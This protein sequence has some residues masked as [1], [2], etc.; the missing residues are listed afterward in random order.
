MK[1]DVEGFYAAIRKN[2]DPED[3][4]GEV[5]S[6]TVHY[7]KVFQKGELINWNWVACLFAPIWMLYRRLYAAYILL[8][9]IS[10][11]LSYLPTGVLL[12]GLVINV[13]IGMLGDSLYIYF[14]KQAHVRD[15]M[16]NPGNI[17]LVVLICSHIIVVGIVSQVQYYFESEAVEISSDVYIDA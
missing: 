15:Q 8:M 11:V 2:Q 9:V 17:P 13:G 14:V 5:S 12:F 10:V 1:F 7:L 6:N 4:N 3:I 16:M